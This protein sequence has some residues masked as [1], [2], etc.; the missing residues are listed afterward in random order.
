MSGSLA[1]ALRPLLC[2]CACTLAVLIATASA[3]AQGPR[4]GRPYRGLFGSG[5]ATGNLEQEVSVDASVGTGYDDNLLADALDLSTPTYSDLST[6]HS[7][8][9]SSASGSISY[10]LNR[11]RVSATANGGTSLRYYPSLETANFVRRNYASGSLNVDIGKGLSAGAL[12]SY[13]PYSSASL[14]PV[15]LDSRTGQVAFDEDLVYS[16]Q[17]YVS[18]E[19]NLRYTHNLSRRTAI[20]L[21]AGYRVNDS[22][23]YLSRFTG[24]FLG[25][26]VT[27]HVTRDMGLRLGYRYERSNYDTGAR[28][29]TVLNHV[30]DAGVDYQRALSKS[31]RTNVA[32][33]TG[34]SATTDRSGETFVRMIGTARLTHEIG[35]SWF[36]SI[37]YER[38]V[39][40]PEGWQ[41][42]VFADSVLAS[43]NGFVTTRVEL[44]AS[45]RASTGSDAFTNSDANTYHT[46]YGNAGASFAINRSMSAGLTYAYYNQMYSDLV[47]LTPGF[48]PHVSR[49]SVRAYISFWAP[50]FQ[51]TRRQ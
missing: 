25:G 8:A 17:H 35:R 4:P 5:N 16:S 41:R 11:D 20:N 36:T 2:S 26:N 14:F 39:D 42:P 6:A 31:R 51:R 15:L 29:Q 10:Q 18:Y 47:L 24:Q 9:V 19:A 13:A 50:V 21:D 38:G 3:S 32:F 40:Y 33:S 23:V 48:P 49:N 37:A 30:I 22:S 46:L 45:V 27:H 1:G 12:A 34:A 43:L 44:E 28:A 7:G